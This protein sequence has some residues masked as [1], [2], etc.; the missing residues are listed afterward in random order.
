MKR[1]DRPQRKRNDD[2]ACGGMS[3]GQRL[4]EARE[5]LKAT[6][7]SPQSNRQLY[8]DTSVCKCPCSCRLVR[9]HVTTDVCAALKYCLRSSFRTSL[10]ANYC[11]LLGLLAINYIIITFSAF[12]ITQHTFSH[13]NFRIAILDTFSMS[14]YYVCL[15]QVYPLGYT[16]V[17]KL[18]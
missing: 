14:F 4:R 15:F 12:F 16:I 13:R 3:G 8:A 1:S 5:A 17:L 10:L 18:M 2:G 9:Q 6:E 7:V 11:M